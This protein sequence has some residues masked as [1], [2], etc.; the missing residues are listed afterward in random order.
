MEISQSIETIEE[1]KEK[2]ENANT[3]EATTQWIR[4]FG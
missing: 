3:R 1:Y 4:V 2:S